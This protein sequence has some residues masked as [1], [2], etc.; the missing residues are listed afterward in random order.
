LDICPVYDNP[1]I[2]LTHRTVLN[3]A[4]GEGIYGVVHFKNIAIGI[5]PLDHDGNTWLV[6][7]YRY[8][9]GAYSWEIP[10]GGGPLGTPPLESAKREL[11]EETGIQ[12]KKWTKLM[13]MHLS[14]SDT[15]EF[16]IAYVAQELHFQKAQPEETEQLLVRRV[17]FS[18]AIQMVMDGEITDALS[19]AALLKTNEYLRIGVLTI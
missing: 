5:V 10:E 8:V 17:P 4:G 12:A 15:N 3:P 14:N 16:S 18:Q 9:L 13:E 11:S 1:W 19:V 7:Q 2:Q 6:G